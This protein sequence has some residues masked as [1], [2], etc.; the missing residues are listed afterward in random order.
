MRLPVSTINSA[1]NALYFTSLTRTY[2]EPE[3]EPL[4]PPGRGR[5]RGGGVAYVRGP[6]L[7]YV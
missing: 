5:G 7:R 6:M 2:A 1:K 3:E 4:V